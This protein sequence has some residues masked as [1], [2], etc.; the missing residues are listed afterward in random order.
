MF[1]TVA[2]LLKKTGNLEEQ[3]KQ[4]VERKAKLEEDNSQL[5]TQNFVSVLLEVAY[6]DVQEEPVFLF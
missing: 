1:T 3:V 5:T 4:A 2:V 6:S